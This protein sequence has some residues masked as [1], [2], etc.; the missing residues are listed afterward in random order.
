ML[1]TKYVAMNTWEQKEVRTRE[2]CSV[3]IK[4]GKN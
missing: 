3:V 1:K 4:F 2:H